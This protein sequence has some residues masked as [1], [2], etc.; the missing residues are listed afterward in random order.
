M[1]QIIK[2]KY[3]TLILVFQEHMTTLI[4]S[5]CRCV[6]ELVDKS[7]QIYGYQRGKGRGGIISSLGLT[8]TY[9]R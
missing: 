8:Y 6:K 2:K 3:I 1:F 7:Q 9:Y 4:P 5:P